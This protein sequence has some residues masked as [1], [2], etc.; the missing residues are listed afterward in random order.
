[1]VYIYVLAEKCR[2]GWLR[3]LARRRRRRRREPN[4]V[5]K[6][7]I[8]GSQYKNIYFSK[9]LACTKTIN[10]SLGGDCWWCC[11]RARRRT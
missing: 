10:K 5:F 6:L 4:T 2:A 11:E 7:Y 3:A 9:L 1:M 8:S